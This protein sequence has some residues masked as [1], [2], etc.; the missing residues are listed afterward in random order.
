MGELTALPASLSKSSFMD[1]K[2][3]TV[4]LMRRKRERDHMMAPAIGGW[5]LEMGGL[6]L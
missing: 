3:I 2:H 1:W 5:F 6:L 4:F